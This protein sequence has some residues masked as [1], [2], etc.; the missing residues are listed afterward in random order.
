MVTYLIIAAV[1]IAAYR[2]WP[3][4]CESIVNTGLAEIKREAT[5]VEKLRAQLD[6]PTP[7]PNQPSA[8]DALAA[9]LA[10]KK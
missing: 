10:T 5:P 1:A 2:Y 3:D 8:V 9:A 6:A 4:I 7:A